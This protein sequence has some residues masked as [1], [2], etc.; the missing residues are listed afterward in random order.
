MSFYMSS[1]PGI[2]HKLF[3]KEI[4]VYTG[5]VLDCSDFKYIRTLPSQN[6]T[7]FMEGSGAIINT[8]QQIME[9]DTKRY[10]IVFDCPGKGQQ[11]RA[12]YVHAGS[13]APNFKGAQLIEETSRFFGIPDRELRLISS[14]GEPVPVL[15][16]D[17]IE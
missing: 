10:V 5:D 12:V 4:A 15:D 8:P 11:T 16:W 7:P 2:L 13:K 6:V 1:G 17:L 3:G 9:V 14:D